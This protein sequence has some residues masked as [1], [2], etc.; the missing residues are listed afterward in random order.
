MVTVFAAAS[1]GEKLDLVSDTVFTIFAISVAATGT[2]AIFLAWKDY[3]KMHRQDQE[4]A[5]CNGEPTRKQGAPALGSRS[6]RT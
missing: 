3:L 5:E 2:A 6:V 1:M 4:R